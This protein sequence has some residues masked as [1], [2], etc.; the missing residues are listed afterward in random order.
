MP[1]PE[2]KVLNITGF[3]GQT[4]PNLFFH[5]PGETTG[6]AVLSPGLRYSCDMPL[7]YYLT[8]LL[9]QRGVDVLQLHTDYTL[10]AFQA[11][12]RLEQASWIGGDA[13]AGVQVG[14]AQRSYPRLVLAGKSIGALALAQL[15]VSDLLPEPAVIWLTPL[16]HQALLVSA[17]QQAKGPALFIC[18]SG[19]AAYDAPALARLRQKAGVQVL[20]LEH[21][22]HSLEIPGDVLRSQRLMEHILDAEAHF[23][24]ELL[25]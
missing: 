16:L 1:E 11:L 15:V 12:N 13:L 6:L 4:V 24:D 5:Q 18:G 21:A 23:L 17:A 14:Q 10:S 3:Q 25:A 22:N 7:L 8:R 20:V 19:D 9:L 2:M